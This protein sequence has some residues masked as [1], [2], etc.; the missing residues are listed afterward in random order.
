[1]PT[2]RR[3]KE[4]YIDVF[5]EDK[6]AYETKLEMTTQILSPLKTTNPKNVA[7]CSVLKKLVS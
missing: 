3:K 4:R 1:M 7:K 2:E 5:K 6:M